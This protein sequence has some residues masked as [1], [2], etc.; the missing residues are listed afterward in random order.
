[1]KKICWLIA[2]LIFGT[3]FCSINAVAHPPQDMILEYDI[4]TNNLEVEITHNTPSPTLHHINNIEIY[5]NDVLEISE[6]YD[7]Q[8][9][10]DVFIKNFDIV[11]DIG[12][13]LKVVAICNIQG[14]IERTIVVEDPEADNPPIVEI[15]NPT[16]G[17]FHFSGIRLFPTV[18]GIVSDTMGF[19][20]FRLRPLQIYTSDDKDERNE[21]DVSVFIDDVK[22]G[23]AEYNPSSGYHE[24][25]W[26]GPN[27]GTFTLK[28]IAEDTSEN[29]AEAT[30]EVWYF[31]FIP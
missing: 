19:G 17:Y 11:A 5:K 1:M 4:D 12:D 14:S 2:I 29:T 26:T 28:A 8:P 31:C 10:T 7:S 16:K 21:I 6:E 23:D 3:S 27:L 22:L 18:F 24:I 9:T 30:M 13:E 25:K 20:G 15:N